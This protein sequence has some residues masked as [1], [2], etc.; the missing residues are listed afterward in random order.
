[1]TRYGKI[2]P[3][4]LVV[5]V[6]MGAISL[7]FLIPLFW[8]ASAAFKYEKDVM[9]FPIQWIPKAWNAVGNFK[10]VW[11]ADIPFY[12]FYWN[13]IKIA[14]IVTLATVVFSSMAAFS[15]TKLNFRGRDLMFGVLLTFMIIPEQATLI[16]RFMFIRWLGLYNTHEALIVTMMFSIYFTFLMRQFMLGIHTDFLE[17][18]KIDGAGY[19]RIYWQIILPLCK[20][21]LATVGIIKF[22]WTWNDYQ[23]PLV[24][25]LDKDLYPITLGIQL[26]KD[27]YA[28]NYAVLMMASLSAIIPLVILFIVLQ[29]QVIKG[30]SL[31]GVKG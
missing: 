10:A 18:A 5:T 28:D 25:L 21:I 1:M 8:M 13:S 19:L 22:I 4:K 17:A 15:F 6:L 31:G 12:T 24:F 23:H 20:P 30:I 16:P 7:F 11:M 27:D 2:D 29:K 14:V 26:F 3:G 9:V